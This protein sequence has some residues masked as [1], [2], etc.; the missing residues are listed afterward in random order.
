M[1]A[2]ERRPRGDEITRRPLEDD[3]SAV[4][5]GAR[6]DVDDPVGVRHHRLMVLD[7]DD[8]LSRVDEA[9]EQTEQVLDIGEMQA[10]GRLVQHIDVGGLTHLDRQ[11][12]A[13]SLT[14]GQR[15]QR[16]TEGQVPEADIRHPRQ[17]RDHG[18]GKGQA[19]VRLVPLPDDAL[20]QPCCELHYEVQASVGGKIAQLG[21]RLIDGAAKG[22]AEDFFRRFDEQ[23]RRRHGRAELPAPD[24]GTADAALTEREG[25]RTVQLDTRPAAPG[26]ERAAVPQPGAG[27]PVWV[28]GAVAALLVAVA[29]YLS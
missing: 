6:S 27:I 21:Q 24:D 15:R 9:I 4:V 19:Q 29:M 26:G 2:G 1:L 20:G 11:L 8:R 14:A 17:H 18:F 3:T 25:A 7:D 16:L 13:L 28:W 5:T 23:L 12:Q 22:L 10:G